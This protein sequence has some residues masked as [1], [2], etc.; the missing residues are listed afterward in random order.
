MDKIE[1][2]QRIKKKLI[3]ITADLDDLNETEN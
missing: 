3:D 2:C 1:V